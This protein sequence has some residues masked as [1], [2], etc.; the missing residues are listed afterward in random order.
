MN[1]GD[2]FFLVGVETARPHLWIVVSDP[3][4]D[5]EQVLIINVTTSTDPPDNAC[6]LH[7]GD[8]PF[9]DRET[10]VY[11]GQARVLSLSQVQLAR[12]CKRL[13]M[14]QPLSQDV[15]KRIRQGAIES[16]YI[17]FKHRKIL[18]DQELVE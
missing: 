14:Q 3:Q 5:P 1:G 13:D 12:D 2:T 15:L 17:M 8:H 11:Y 7:A 9:I 18:I 6:I 16:D 4:I 10:Y